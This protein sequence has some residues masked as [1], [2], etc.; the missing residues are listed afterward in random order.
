MRVIVFLLYP[1]YNNNNLI[2]IL[3]KIHVNMKEKVGALIR[4]RHVFAI[5][6]QAVAPFLGE[7]G[8]GGLI[9]GNAICRNVSINRRYD[10]NNNKPN[11]LLLRLLCLRDEQIISAMVTYLL[12]SID[13]QFAF[14]LFHAER[15][16]Y[17]QI[18]YLYVNKNGILCDEIF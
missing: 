15:S 6:A 8:W 3:R 12:D 18:R 5:M 1:N 4:G 11:H 2:L 17:E 13:L 16:V 14:L 10:N 7:W 9:R